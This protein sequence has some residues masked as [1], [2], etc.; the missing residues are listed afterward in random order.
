[1]MVKSWPL[2]TLAGIVFILLAPGVVWFAVQLIKGNRGDTLV[3]APF[4]VQQEINLSA[5]GEVVVMI[6]MPQLATDF[7]DF[8]IE[9]TGKK[10]GQTEVMKYSYLGSQGA[11]HGVPNLRMPYGRMNANAGTYVA[12]I[13]GLNPSKDYSA[14]QLVFSRPY[15]TRMALQII[16]IVFCVVG[17]LG[18]LIWAVW[19]MGLM[20]QGQYT[21]S[22]Q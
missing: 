21:P 9:L 8:Q 12:R 18:C 22:P 16:G 5:S 4:V 10:T 17:M 6:D 14:Y 7:K 11:I 2:L 19:L 20:K 13:T 3:S 15:G 1:M